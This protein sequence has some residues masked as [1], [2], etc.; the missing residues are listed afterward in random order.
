MAKQKRK[1]RAMDKLGFKPP[2][3][4]VERPELPDPAEIK[5]R[6]TKTEE[7]AVP[8]PASQPPK[9]KAATPKAKTPKTPKPEKPRKRGRPI[10]K[11]GFV[12]FTSLMAPETLQELKILAIRE[13]KHL[14]ELLT[15]A[16]E[17]LLKKYNRKQK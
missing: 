11:H 17:D 5:K 4:P 12:T 9:P 16:G 14:F 1:V 15:E 3:L 2:A 6:I 8:K 7:P 10:A 13:Q